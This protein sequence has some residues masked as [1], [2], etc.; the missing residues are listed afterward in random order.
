MK[1]LIYIRLYA[2]REEENELIG[3]K[4]K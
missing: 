1:P 3:K 4:N 2:G